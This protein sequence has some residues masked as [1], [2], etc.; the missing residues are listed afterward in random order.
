MNTL[1][2]TRSKPPSAP[3][4]F[5]PVLN[6]GQRRVVEFDVNDRHMLV[7]APPGSGKTL[8]ITHRIARLLTSR[9]AEPENIL[10]LTFTERAAGEL[11]TRLSMMSLHGVTARTFHGYC[12]LILRRYRTEAGFAEAFSVWNADQQERY[13]LESIESL[14][15]GYLTRGQVSRIRRAIS[16]YR[17]EPLS[18]EEAAS[19][20]QLSIPQFERLMENYRDVQR[21]QNA[22]DFDDLIVHTAELLWSDRDVATAVHDR[23]GFVFVDEFQDVSPDQ[24]RLLNSI[25]PHQKPSRQ[26]VVVADENQS[27]YAFRGADPNAMLGSYRSLYRPVTFYLEENRRSVATIVRCARALM[28]ASSEG[29]EERSVAYREEGLVPEGLVCADGAEEARVVASLVERAL[30]SRYKGSDVAI[31]YR[32]HERGDLI[33][34]A[35]LDRRIPLQRVQKGRF[36]DLPEVQET[37]RSFELVASS[38]D[39]SFVNAVNWPRFLVD[40]LTMNSIRRLAQERG[41]GLASIATTPG[42]LREGCSPLTATVVQ[43]FFDEVVFPV[44]AMDSQDP[45]TVIPAVLDLLD[46]RRNPVSP[47]ERDDI[48]ATLDEVGQGLEPLSE[49]LEL[50]IDSGGPVSIRRGSSEDSGRAA[51]LLH[52]TL[53]RYFQIDAT[54]TDDASKS[55]S[56]DISSL[57]HPTNMFTLTSRAWR[58]AQRLLMRRETLHHGR[59]VVYDMETTSD[60]PDLAEM[61]EIGGVI[62]ENGQVIGDSFETRVRPSSRDVMTDDAFA[63]HG[64]RWVD[65]EHAP[66]PAD[67]IEKFR[68]YAGESTLAGHNIQRFDN[69]VLDYACRRAGLP[70]FDLPVLDTLL[71]ARRLRPGKPNSL[72]DLLTADERNL[73]GQHRAGTD[74]RLNAIAMIRLVEA[75]QRDREVDV[76]AEELPYV[77]ASFDLHPGELGPDAQ[78]LRQLGAR[79]MAISGGSGFDPEDKELRSIRELAS[80]IDSRDQSWTR[81]QKGWLNIVNNF[82]EVARNMTLED[83]MDLVALATPS[84]LDERTDSR[85]T[86]MTIYAAKG[87]EWPIVFMVGVE[88]DQYPYSSNNL[89]SEVEDGRRSLYVGM[90]RATE[91]LFLS[92]AE[93]FDRKRRTPSRFI[94]DLG[95]TVKWTRPRMEERVH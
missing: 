55:V 67:V 76:L 74:A 9:L 75:L 11:V 85:V 24:M 25:A 51:R 64:I 29:A 66:K 4:R 63:I 56:F 91:R 41:V 35:L 47:D 19:R 33:E 72:D 26:V 8:T 59:F 77:A 94:A 20:S 6:E 95:D 81:L 13:Q 43:H 27:I 32:R 84:D 88:D 62:V 14:G 12:S 7:L 86:M 40:E 23:W 22:I 82:R 30:K 53:S 57:Q 61:L 52:R 89:A 46:R 31:L 49:A 2:D 79:S 37:I 54:V 3:D 58:L 18:L 83:F 80:R 17:C 34:N 38:Q 39:R 36:Y 42:L 45:A 71:L 48:R 21:D 93:Y 44:R 10:A 50:A 16:Q 28:A 90:T 68:R 87:K 60:R 70:A 78:M 69:V 73:R 15:L 65:V 92:H 1:E 5:N